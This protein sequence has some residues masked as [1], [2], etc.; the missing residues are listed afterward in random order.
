MVKVIA[1]RR[2]RRLFRF[3][4]IALLLGVNAVIFWRFCSAGLPSQFKTLSPNHTLAAAY[5]AQGEKLTAFT[6]KQPSIT[7]GTESYGYFSVEQCVFYPEAK[8]VQVVFR[9]NDSTLTH[10]AEDK[11][12][13][14]TPPKSG[15][16]FDVTLLRTT[17]LTPKDKTDN[18]DPATLAQNR[19]H[20]TG[21]P[22]RL[23]TS[24]YTYFRYTF[25]GVEFEKDTDGIFV[26]VYWLG[27][28][29]YKE[30][31]YGTLVIWDSGSKNQTVELSSADHNALR[32]WLKKESEGTP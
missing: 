12:L 27:D 9:Y 6:Q 1:R 31:S 18:S 16:Y 7:R 23:E 13:S 17:D 10:L 22:E 5:A 19:Y 30:S 29:N 20:A 8:Q 28:L 14:E 26:D 3:F 11:K 21:T 4:V 24:L 2:L 25:D 32:E 15:T